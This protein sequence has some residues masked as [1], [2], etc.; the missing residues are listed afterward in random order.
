MGLR[1]LSALSSRVWANDAQRRGQAGAPQEIRFQ[2]KPDMALGHI[3]SPVNEA[4]P[5]G[6][7]LADAAY[8]DD[9]AFRGG[10]ETL[11][12]SYAVGIKSSTSL[13]PPRTMPLPPQPR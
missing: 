5:R 10:I 11:G 12:L 13:W 2:T 3:R 4:V 9:N 6:V 1:D 7:V 8:G